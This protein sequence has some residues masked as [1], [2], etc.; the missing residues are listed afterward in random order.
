MYSICIFIIKQRLSEES[1]LGF[2]SIQHLLLSCFLCLDHFNEF[3]ENWGG[4]NVN[5]EIGNNALV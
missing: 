1:F 3:L 2:S 4:K 5:V